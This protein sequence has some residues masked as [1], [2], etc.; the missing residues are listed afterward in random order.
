[1]CKA[2]D[3]ETV[4]RLVESGVDVNKKDD[5]GRTP[6]H[7][8]SQY[9]HDRLVYYLV[10]HGADIYAV[11]GEGFVPYRVA[12]NNGYIDIADYLAEVEDWSLPVDQS[13][14]VV[15]VAPQ[16]KSVS[17][18]QTKKLTKK[19]RK[20]QNPPIAKVK[21]K[22]LTRKE[23]KQQNQSA[24]SV[25]KQVISSQKNIVAQVPQQQLV[26]QVQNQNFGRQSNN[27]QITRTDNS[28]HIYEFNTP[29]HY[30]E[31]ILFKDCD[32]CLAPGVY[33][34]T[35]H[36]LNRINGPLTSS[37]GVI[38]YNPL[39][40]LRFMEHVLSK[41]H[42]DKRH[43]FSQNVEAEGGSWARIVIKNA[44]DDTDQLLN[45]V[46]NFEILVTIPGEIKEVDN[47][48]GQAI[49]IN[50][51]S[52]VFEFAIRKN[53]YKARGECFHRFFAPKGMVGAT[54]FGA[55]AQNKVANQ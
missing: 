43:S 55:K 28:I 1:L 33:Y 22:K 3:I 37:N 7:I 54:S 32:N 25:Q 27:V 45:G 42:G 46:K 35:S 39:L 14:V 36:G 40:N 16:Q 52:G 20:Q 53:L 26:N 11:D 17:Q 48:T 4:S 5:H 2:G 10:N 13:N 15:Q 18:L 34:R 49:V 30:T 41:I 44:I 31:T 47:S 21:S 51:L 19:E 50:R 29:D 12:F 6:L 9:G 8:A 24:Q 23:K 38:M